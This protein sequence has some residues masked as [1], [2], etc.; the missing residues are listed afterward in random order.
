MTN[1]KVIPQPFDVTTAQ[2]E[3]LKKLFKRYYPDHINE[4]EQLTI[5]DSIKPG[6]YIGIWTNY[7]AE[8]GF[9][10][11]YIGIETDGYYHT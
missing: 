3:T 7:S 8:K 6:E 2:L 10:G 1:F 9:H 5:D 4:L 11:V